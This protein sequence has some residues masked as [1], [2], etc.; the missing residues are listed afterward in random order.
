MFLN[1]MNTSDEPKWFIYFVYV[2]QMKTAGVKV[3][4]I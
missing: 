4:D 3:A 1:N 2:P